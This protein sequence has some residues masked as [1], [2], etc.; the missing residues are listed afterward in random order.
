M[1]ISFDHVGI[2][3][4]DLDT[5]VRWY[6]AALGLQHDFSFEIA[7]HDF[8]GVVLRSPLGFRIELLQRAGSAP[9]LRAPDPLTAALT[10][11]YGHMAVRVPRPEDVDAVFL[12]LLEAGATGRMA[13]QAAPE[14]GS[15]MAFVADPEGNLIEILSRGETS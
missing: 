3:V 11:G 12:A 5:A 14:P 10:R 2:T 15:R 13:P 9:G 8:R 6:C 7:E 1:Q 4:A